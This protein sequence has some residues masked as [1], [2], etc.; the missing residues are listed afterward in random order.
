[1]INKMFPLFLTLLYLIFVIFIFIGGGFITNVL[2]SKPIDELAIV[3]L[4]NEAKINISKMTIVLF[5][6]V[7]IP[8]CMLPFVLLAAYYL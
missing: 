6:I 4:D 2:F 5:W 7:F 1:M 8:L 3:G